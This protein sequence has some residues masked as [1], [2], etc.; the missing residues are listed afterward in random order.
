MQAPCRLA[1]VVGC[2]MTVKT[3]TKTDEHIYD[4]EDSAVRRTLLLTGITALDTQMPALAAQAL[5]GRTLGTVGPVH[6]NAAHH[7]AVPLDRVDFHAQV[8]GWNCDAE[9]VL[10]D[11]LCCTNHNT[12]FSQQY[13]TTPLP[14]LQI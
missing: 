13:N 10:D 5:R 4:V 7:G 9:R 8:F 3:H 2:E 11:N 6:T 1:H 14:A 12:F